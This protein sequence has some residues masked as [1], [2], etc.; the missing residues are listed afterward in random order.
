MSRSSGFRDPVGRREGCYLVRR[1]VTLP[2]RFFV[3]APLSMVLG[4]CLWITDKEHIDRT[5]GDT[6]VVDTAAPDTDDS[7]DTVGATNV[8]VR[9]Q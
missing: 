9:T 2:G 5:Q 6:D 4:G 1:E 8:A 7:G 3:L